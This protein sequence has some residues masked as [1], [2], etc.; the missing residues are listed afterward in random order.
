[1]L[2]KLHLGCGKIF[3]PGFIHIDQEPWDHLD[4]QRN[5]ENLDIFENNSID[6]IYTCHSFGYY[7]DDQALTALKEW[8][9]VLK[10]CGLLRLATPDFE[11]ISL[12]YLKFKDLKLVKRLVTGYYQSK[13]KTMY[14]KSVYD[15]LTLCDLLQ[16]AGFK[17][18]HRYDW[19]DTDFAEYDDYSKAYLPHMDKAN[20]I[21]MS[22]NVEAIK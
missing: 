19:Q 5:I 15:E 11:A 4:Y 14:H 22:L 21:L 20:G 18:P 7:D 10:P 17:N 8:Y 6:M 9:R 1:M 3:I 2:K 12:A 16:E 13:G